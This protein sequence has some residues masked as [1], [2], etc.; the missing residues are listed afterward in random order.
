MCRRLRRWTALYGVLN[1]TFVRMCWCKLRPRLRMQRW[2]PTGS[3]CRASCRPLLRISSG[4]RARDTRRWTWVR[5][6]VRIVGVVAR[7]VQAEEEAV[8]VSVIT[9][10]RKDTSS[11]SARNLGGRRQWKP[12]QKTRRRGSSEP[13]ARGFTRSSDYHA[14]HD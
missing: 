8:T 10:V 11:E 5:W 12:G 9:A 14:R 7:E 1:H 3:R 2:W 4:R 13:R 6:R